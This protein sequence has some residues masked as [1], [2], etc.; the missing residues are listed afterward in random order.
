MPDSVSVSISAYAQVNTIFRN[1]FHFYFRFKL[2]I[3]LTTSKPK[4]H[5]IHVL[6]LF[7]PLKHI[8]NDV[9]I[10]KYNFLT[11]SLYLFLLSICEGSTLSQTSV[12]PYPPHTLNSIICCQRQHPLPKGTLKPPSRLRSEPINTDYL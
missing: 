12:Q 9:L 1:S 6:A 2:I 7:R 8:V 3:V 4:C 10:V 11:L 5:H